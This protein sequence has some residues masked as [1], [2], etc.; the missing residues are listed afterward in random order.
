MKHSLD[1][2]MAT[3][4]MV[5][6]SAL[7]ADSRFGSFVVRPALQSPA[8]EAAGRLSARSSAIAPTAPSR[9]IRT[10]LLTMTGDG[11]MGKRLPAMVATATLA[12]TGIGAIIV[13]LPA[14]VITGPLSAIGA[15]K[16]PS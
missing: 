1:L 16:S 4:L 12:A 7:A 8:L 6:G 9:A 2:T 5:A 3:V 13:R 11:A 10:G 15:G 14:R